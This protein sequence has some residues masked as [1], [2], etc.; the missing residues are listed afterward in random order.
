MSDKIYSPS[1]MACAGC[2]VGGSR[3]ASSYG[4]YTFTRIVTCGIAGVIAFAGFRDR[5]VVQAWSV[6]LALVAVLFN[7]IVPVH[8]DRQTWFYLDLGAAAVFVAHLISCAGHDRPR[9]SGIAG[10]DELLGYGVPAEWLNDIKRSTEDTL[11]ALT[12]HLRLR[13]RCW[14]LRRGASPAYPG[15]WRER[16]LLSPVSVP[17]KADPSPQ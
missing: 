3:L 10:N 8:L 16:I 1:R 12:D 5:A 7:P 4:Y 6:L 13:R 2:P 17:R 11:L 9:N 14:N 15:P